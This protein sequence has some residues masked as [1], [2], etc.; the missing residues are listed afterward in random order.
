MVSQSIDRRKRGR[1]KRGIGNG[2]KFQ[3]YPR[4]AGRGSWWPEMGVVTKKMPSQQC[5]W[6]ME[7]NTFRTVVASVIEEAPE[8]PT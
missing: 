3:F 4:Y 1:R 7:V 2:S 8:T 6:I 5:T